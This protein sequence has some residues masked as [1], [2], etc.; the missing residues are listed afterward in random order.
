MSGIQMPSDKT[1]PQSCRAGLLP[2]RG[3]SVE[4]SPA[5]TGLISGRIPESLLDIGKPK[6]EV[7]LFKE[8]VSWMN[9]FYFI[10]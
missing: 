4:D 5:Q 6:F 7:I 2:S 3:P 10:K 1:D 9:A 8:N